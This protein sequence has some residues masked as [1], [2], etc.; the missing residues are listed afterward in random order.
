MARHYWVT[1][2]LLNGE[3]Y[4]HQV[5]TPVQVLSELSAEYSVGMEMNFW[6]MGG[7][8]N[9]R[10][11]LAWDEEGVCKRWGCFLRKLVGLV[12]KQETCAELF[13][14]ECSTSQNSNKL[15]IL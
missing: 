9:R 10:W 6:G 15:Q 11:G 13:N 14:A 7:Y 8:G 12:M 4:L 2:Y 5:D 1:G 3:V